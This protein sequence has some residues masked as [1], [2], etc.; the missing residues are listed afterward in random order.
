MANKELKEFSKTFHAEI[1]AE[2]HSQ[3]TLRE[4]V[5]VEKMGAILEDYGEV[6]SLTFCQYQSRGAKVDGYCYDDEFKDIVLVVSHFIDK[7]DT[8]ES[9]VT[10]TEITTAFKRAAGFFQSALKKGHRKIEVANEA[11]DLARTIHECRKEIRSVKIVLITDGITKKRPAEVQEVDGVDV[12]SVVWDLERTFHFYSTGERE[13]IKIDFKE[14]CDG[15][16]P[17]V[18]HGKKGVPYTT[19]VGFI[20]G[21]TLADFYAQWG[22]NMLDMNVRVFLSA[23]GMSTRR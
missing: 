13:S 8:S 23:R 12:T 5:F 2:S 3:E 21:N 6:E 4:E 10:N 7:A 19:Y 16:L 22:I 20:P 9:S 18:V 1:R 17:C 15:P 14:H 11:H